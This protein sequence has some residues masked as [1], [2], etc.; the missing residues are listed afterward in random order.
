[1][2]F[3]SSKVK[4]PTLTAETTEDTCTQQSNISLPT[5]WGWRDIAS[6]EQGLAVYKN[7]SRR[8]N[9]KAEVSPLCVCLRG[10]FN[11]DAHLFSSPNR[12]ILFSLLT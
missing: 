8:L 3:S 2:I 12:P 7:S 6:T 4:F 10:E 5:E 1:M 9:G 11:K